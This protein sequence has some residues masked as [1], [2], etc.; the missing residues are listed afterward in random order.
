MLATIIIAAAIGGGLGG[1]LAHR[2]SSTV[3][4]EPLQFSTDTASV[5][6][7]STAPN[8]TVLSATQNISL[9]THTAMTTLQPTFTATQ[10]VGPTATLLRDCPASNNSLYTIQFGSRS[11]QE[12]RKSCSSSFLNAD[13]GVG[14]LYGSNSV[15][16]FTT[17]LDN[18]INVCA[19]FNAFNVTANSALP[20]CS[21]VC[22]RNGFGN[23]EFPGQCF[24]YTTANNSGGFILNYTE[25][26]CD[27][28]AWINQ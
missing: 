14:S 9:L 28:A 15:N 8:A 12:F 5:T 19:S 27:S 16:I 3:A 21:A 17:S 24:G 18:C 22:W 7:L 6:S 23:N 26:I 1:G 2:A 11:A 4:Q 20:P 25:T 13:Y 10:V